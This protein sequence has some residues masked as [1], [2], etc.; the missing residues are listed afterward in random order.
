MKAG[1]STPR[2]YSNVLRMLFA[3]YSAHTHHFPFSHPHLNKKSILPLSMFVAY[4]FV[5]SGFSGVC[6]VSCDCY[7]I[8]SVFCL[9]CPLWFCGLDMFCLLSRCSLC[10]ID[11]VLCYTVLQ[12]SPVLWTTTAAQPLLQNQKP[13]TNPPLSAPAKTQTVAPFKI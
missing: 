2:Q 4:L 8:V 1:T 3:T 9:P 12:P 7:C 10:E 13:T 5:S 6:L 11:V